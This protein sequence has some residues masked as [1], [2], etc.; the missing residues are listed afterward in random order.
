MLVHSSSAF[1]PCG[2]PPQGGEEVRAVQEGLAEVCRHL[3]APR[4]PSGHNDNMGIFGRT[5]KNSWHA[6]NQQ[7]METSVLHKSSFFQRIEVTKSMHTIVSCLSLAATAVFINIYP[8]KGTT[9]NKTKIWYYQLKSTCPWS[10]A[11]LIMR[12]EFLPDHRLRIPG[13]TRSLLHFRKNK[14]YLVST[15]LWTSACPGGT[16]S[17]RAEEEHCMISTP[18]SSTAFP[19]SV[20]EGSSQWKT[21]CLRLCKLYLKMSEELFLVHSFAN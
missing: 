21:Y 2:S 16:S 7:E 8:L 20:H 18:G 3:R 4:V 13:G 1:F 15:F 17:S 10:N 19:C 6:N 14:C 5:C 11:Q 12:K 9:F